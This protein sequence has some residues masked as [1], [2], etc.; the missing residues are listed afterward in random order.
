MFYVVEERLLDLVK[1]DTHMNRV[2][3]IRCI[4]KPDSQ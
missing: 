2:E 1:F 4:N 3:Q